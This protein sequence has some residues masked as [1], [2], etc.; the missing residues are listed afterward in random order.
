MLVVVVVEVAVVD[1]LVEQVEVELEY[2]LQDN[3]I[4]AV[5]EEVMITAWHSQ[6]DLVC[7]L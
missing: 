7:A 1:I 6:V 2:L 5:A 3:Q 4:L